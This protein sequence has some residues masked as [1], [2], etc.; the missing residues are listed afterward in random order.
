MNN[1]FENGK[2]ILKQ[3]NDSGYEAYFVG[4]VVRDQLLNRPTSDIDITTNATPPQVQAI[5]DKTILT[6]KAFGT[7][8]VLIDKIPYEVTT[9][10]HDMK[11]DNH[12]HP[13]NIKFAKT[14]KD[15]LSRRDFTINQLTMDVDGNVYDYFNG[16]QDLT[17]K[18]IQ[19]IG[20][21]YKRFEEDALRILRA[22]RFA[23]TL[24]FT[25]EDNTLNAIKDTT[26]LIRK[27]STER[28]QDELFKLLNGDST[29]Y[30]IDKIIET[31]THKALYLEKGFL[32]LNTLK[33]NDYN[34]TEALVM[35]QKDE[36]FPFDKYH[37][38]NKLI[39]HIQTITQ[40]HQAT[41]KKGFTPMQ[42]FSYELDDVLR[43]N[44]VNILRGDIDRKKSIYALNDTLP[45]KTPKSLAFK[46][47][48]IKKHLD[49]DTNAQ[50]ST[51]LHA[52]ITS[53]VSGEVENDFTTLKTHAKKIL[54]DLKDR[55]HYA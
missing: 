35:M 43:A 8:T 13:T 20:N 3:L 21:P 32:T 31:N 36:A 1:T 39:K 50:I 11:Y 6:G 38:S 45:I 53:V 9:Y 2:L 23:A 25:I 42:V 4:G 46:G 40:L 19:T 26:H 18:I 34:A 14:L 15:D 10:R 41:Y 48:D 37:F 17:A 22:F 16:K 12:R 44:R 52:L 5:F 29:A 24:A 28:V 47:N 30:V 49:L 7:I 55:D 27:I 54:K 33:T 51:I